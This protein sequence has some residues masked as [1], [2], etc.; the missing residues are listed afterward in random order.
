MCGKE[1]DELILPSGSAC[2]K[3]SLTRHSFS[4]NFPQDLQE[5]GGREM[6]N[7]V[8]DGGGCGIGEWGWDGGIG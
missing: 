5:W 6:W 3:T 8:S 4:D 7:G 1:Y 2:Q